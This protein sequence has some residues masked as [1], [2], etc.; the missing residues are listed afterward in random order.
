MIKN[1][2]CV[3]SDPSRERGLELWPRL[4]DGLVCDSQHCWGGICYLQLLHYIGEHYFNLYLNA[5]LLFRLPGV[6]IYVNNVFCEMWHQCVCVCARL[7]C[8]SLLP[9]HQWPSACST[10]TAAQTACCSFRHCTNRL[11]IQPFSTSKWV[12]SLTEICHW[13]EQCMSHLTDFVTLCI[14]GAA[15]ANWWLTWHSYNGVRYVDRVKLRR[16]RLMLGLV[17]APV[18]IHS[19][20]LS[21]SGW[22]QWVMAIVRNV[23]K[24]RQGFVQ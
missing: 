15:L 23:C 12:D 13:N 5:S 11:R 16:A 14:C 21:L 2:I 1:G 22:V 3:S 6:V 8:S 19:A 7:Y 9:L 17:T 24:K 20:W 4:N 10:V 18:F